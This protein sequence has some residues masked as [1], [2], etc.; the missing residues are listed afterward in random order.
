MSN[1]PRAESGRLWR[2]WASGQYNQ[3]ANW[4][5]PRH[6]LLCGAAADASHLCT[7]CKADLPR[8][9]LACP[10]CGVSVQ[11]E[12]LCAA[13][14]HHPPPFTSTIAPLAY[15]G[16]VRYLL[17]QFKFHGRL[18]HGEPLRVALHEAV[19]GREIDMPQALIP[20]PIHPKRLAER[21]F[22][23]A[24]ELAR[25]LARDL[26]IPVLLNAVQRQRAT[27][28]QFQLSGDERVANV[29]GAFVL[30]K[31]VD[32]PKHV[33][34]VD[35]VLTTGATVRELTKLLRKNGCERVDVWCA[36][37]TVAGA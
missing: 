12:G 14:L 32:M 6:C 20:V 37:R 31:G 18:S 19:S 3:L 25:P 10:Q 16:S 28:P 36:A 33:A 4:L 9:A 5:L 30:R 13:C 22:N 1:Q 24:V 35:D 15:K 2:S 17:T 21:G 27:V 29:R 34:I 11:T 7:G 23:Q 26:R 8:I